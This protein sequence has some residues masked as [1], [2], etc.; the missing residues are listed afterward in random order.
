MLLGDF[1]PQTPDP[2]SVISKIKIFPFQSFN[3]DSYM[4]VSMLSN[5][6]LTS[7][8]RPPTMFYISAKLNNFQTSNIEYRYF[9]EC[10]QLSMVSNHACYHLLQMFASNMHQNE[11][12]QVW[13]SKMFW[14]A[15]RAPSPDPSPVF[16]RVLLSIRASPSILRRFAPST[17]ASPSILGRFAPSIRATPSTFDWRTWFGLPK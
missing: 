12:L 15:H 13:F 4:N 8:P 7:S 17:R 10:G 3:V 9:H 6:M 16:P 11:W 5:H 1:V 2:V 14:G